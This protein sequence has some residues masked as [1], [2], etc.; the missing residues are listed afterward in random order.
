MPAFPVTVGTDDLS[1]LSDF[2]LDYYYVI[3]IVISFYWS[4]C[5]WLL[6]LLMPKAEA[7]PENSSYIWVFSIFH[8]LFFYFVIYFWHPQHSQWNCQFAYFIP[9][10]SLR[11]YKESA[12]NKN[13]W[14]NKSTVLKDFLTTWKESFKCILYKAI[15]HLALLCF[16]W[17]M[18]NTVRGQS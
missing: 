3:V 18:T 6:T 7:L 15:F 11:L 17:L 13:I 9:D 10:W 4:Q 12:L 14:K 5:T 16:E 1:Y 8:L 2:F